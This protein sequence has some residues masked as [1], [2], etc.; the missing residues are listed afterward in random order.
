MRIRRKRT[1]QPDLREFSFFSSTYLSQDTARE[2]P[3]MSWL[4]TAE[5]AVS[6]FCN[7]PG[8]LTTARASETIR[9]D[10]DLCRWGFS[11]VKRLTP[12]PYEII[13]FSVLSADVWIASTSRSDRRHTRCSRTLLG[14]VVHAPKQRIKIDVSIIGDLRSSPR[15]SNPYSST[16]RPS[17]GAIVRPCDDLESPTL[18]CWTGSMK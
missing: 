13:F 17:G 12:T 3:N 18:L 16:V 8:T 9:A 15:F 1:D 11:E 6:L 14:Q 10:G 5:V 7:A 2:T 4:T